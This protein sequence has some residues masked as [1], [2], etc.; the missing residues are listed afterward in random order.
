MRN[1]DSVK[2]ILFSYWL[3]RERYESEDEEQRQCL[4]Y[5]ILILT[6]E[7]EVGE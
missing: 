7:R 5:P 2:F 6:G 3:V 4:I 1:R